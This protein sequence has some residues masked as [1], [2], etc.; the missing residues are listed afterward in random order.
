MVGVD[1][2]S[3]L[4]A[5]CAW[6]TQQTGKPKSRNER[7]AEILTEHAR[8]EARRASLIARVAGSNPALL[9]GDKL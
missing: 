8:R 1:V 6:F 2:A 5:E 7:A 4:D 9:D 3:V